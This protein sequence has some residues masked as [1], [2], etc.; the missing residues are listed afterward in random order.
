V[1]KVRLKERLI[2]AVP[3]TVRVFIGSRLG[4][5]RGNPWLAGKWEDVTRYLSFKWRTKRDAMRIEVSDK[6]YL[7]S[8]P[9]TLPSIFEESDGYLPAEF[10]RVI[11]V[12][13]ESG[14]TT[15]IDE[16]RC[17]KP[18]RISFRSCRGSEMRVYD[19]YVT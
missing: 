12:T 18:C 16:I 11:E 17:W 2:P 7:A 15:E 8:F 3:V 9:P 14:D 13:G 6:G 10:D 4:L 19:G 5:A 1:G